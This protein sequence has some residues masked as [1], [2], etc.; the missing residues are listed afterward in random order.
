MF[1][2]DDGAFVGRCGIHRIVIDG[3]DEVEIQR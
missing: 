3:R 1:F 2:D